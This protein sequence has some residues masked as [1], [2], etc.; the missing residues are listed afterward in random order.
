MIC[1]LSELQSFCNIITAALMMNNK[2]GYTGLKRERSTMGSFID[3][4]IF[5]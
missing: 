3:E 5:E 1:I 2:C 4:P